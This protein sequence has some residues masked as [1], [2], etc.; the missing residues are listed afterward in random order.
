LVGKKEQLATSTNRNRRAGFGGCIPTDA[1][2]IRESRSTTAEPRHIWDNLLL[3]VESKL[4][5]RRPVW[6]I[7]DVC[8]I[9]RQSR[10]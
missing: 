5:A 10:S 7:R 9:A 2:S 1:L 6:S 8:R 3:R 4:W